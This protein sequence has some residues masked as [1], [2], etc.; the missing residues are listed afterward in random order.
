[1]DSC[2]WTITKAGQSAHVDSCMVMESCEIEVQLADVCSAACR[3]CL[4][5]D[6]A[7]CSAAAVHTGTHE[8]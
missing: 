2:L 3:S 6:A 4:A 5:Q 1:M 7:V 8:G